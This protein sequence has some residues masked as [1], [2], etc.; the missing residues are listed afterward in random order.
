MTETSVCFGKAS[1]T[2][3]DASAT[4]PTRALVLLPACEAEA[5]PDSCAFFDFPCPCP[6]A[7]ASSTADSGSSYGGGAENRSCDAAREIALVP[8]GIAGGSVSVAGSSCRSGLNGMSGGG[9]ATAS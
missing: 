5:S 8:H 7:S 3:Q 4:I 9:R 2:S 1:G 6:T